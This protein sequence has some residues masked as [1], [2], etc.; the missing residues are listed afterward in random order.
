MPQTICPRCGHDNPDAPLYCANCRAD[1]VE[2]AQA[3]QPE[4]STQRPSS[5]AVKAITGTQKAIIAGGA[6]LLLIILVAN[7][8]RVNQNQ[9]DA[10]PTQSAQSAPAKSPDPP[11]R[12]EAPRGYSTMVQNLGIIEGVQSDDGK[13]SRINTLLDQLDAKYPESAQQIGD[14]TAAAYNEIRKKGQSASIIGI[15][16]AMMKVSES[17]TKLSYSDAVTSY[18]LLRVNGMK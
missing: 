10:P 8:N 6:I 7:S 2:A 13:L 3:R 5:E 12:S 1:L 9:R 4:Q 15:M 18:A 17:K 16:E 14:M 11:T